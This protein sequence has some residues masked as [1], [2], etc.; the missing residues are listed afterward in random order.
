MY[1][2]QATVSPPPPP[3]HTHTPYVAMKT[4]YLGT[5]YCGQT[6]ATHSYNIGHLH[7]LPLVVLGIL[8]TPHH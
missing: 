8:D 6:A 3:T 7:M 4:S 1:F 2:E 5:Q